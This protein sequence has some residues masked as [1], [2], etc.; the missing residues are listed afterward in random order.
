MRKGVWLVFLVLGVS[1]MAGGLREQASSSGLA[2]IPANKNEMM[3]LISNQ[4]NLLTR[5]KIDLGKTLYFDP[6]LSKSGLISCNTCHNLGLGGADGVPAAVGDHWAHNPHHLNSPT[7]Y[8]AVFHQVQMWDGRFADLE[9]QAGG[10]MM[11]APEMASTEELVVG[12]I[13]S[14]PGYQEVFKKAFPDE[15]EAVT[16]VNIRKA[17]AAFE[18]TLITPSRFDTYM[19]GDNK[20]LSAAEIRGLSAFVE[21]GCATCHNGVALGGGMQPFPLVKPYAFADLGDFKGNKDGLVKVPTLRNVTETAPYFHN[22]AVWKLADAVKIMGETQLGVTLSKGEINDIVAF[23][24]SLE[25]QKP[26]MNYPMLP[27]SSETTPKPVTR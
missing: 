15:E 21:K 17:I 26:Q 6:R 11:S 1:A 25:G 4:E 24:G 5:D 10:P 20:A 13:A 2:A 12:R 7:V 22:G 9:E 18:R 14:I 8:N 19:L 16:F 27:A 23:L 3:K